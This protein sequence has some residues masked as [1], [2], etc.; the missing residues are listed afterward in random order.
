MKY[1]FAQRDKKSKHEVV[2]DAEPLATAN[3]N[4]ANE[5][6]FASAVVVT[7][8]TELLTSNASSTLDRP[9]P[10]MTELLAP[11]PGHS[12]IQSHES[13]RYTERW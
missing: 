11:S 5:I 13:C 4:G 7:L 6:M 10:A 12:T 8:P 2:T 9:A 3:D 1:Y